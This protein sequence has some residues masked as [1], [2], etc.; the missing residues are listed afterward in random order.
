MSP[1][2]KDSP[3]I[4]PGPLHKDSKGKDSIE[5]VKKLHR[6]VESAFFIMERKLPDDLALGMAVVAHWAITTDK[7]TDPV[8]W[9]EVMNT[10]DRSGWQVNWDMSPRI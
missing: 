7:I 5:L 2:L 8:S 1:P 10:S 9:L 4:L 6:Y 3:P